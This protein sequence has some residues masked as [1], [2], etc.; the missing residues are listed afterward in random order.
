MLRSSSRRFCFSRYEYMDKAM[1]QGYLSSF[2]CIR[3]FFSGNTAIFALS[4]AVVSSCT[5]QNIINT[6]YR[7]VV[8]LTSGGSCLG[9]V[10]GAFVKLDEY[11]MYT[12]ILL[13]Q[14]FCITFHSVSGDLEDFR[15]IW[16]LIKH[17]RTC[18]CSYICWLHIHTP[19]RT[20]IVCTHVH[21]Y[22]RIQVCT[23]IHASVHIYA[24]YRPNA[25][26]H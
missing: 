19:R 23:Y 21:T 3:V 24:Y 25:W 5:V 1:S 7:V 16:V 11:N 17:T 12:A 6:F 15:L 2:S 26:L 22:G 20:C 10:F 8:Y 18:I 9:C 13:I 14:K 4:S